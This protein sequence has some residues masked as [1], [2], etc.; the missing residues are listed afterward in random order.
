[1]SNPWES[2]PELWKT[3]ASFMSYVRGGIRRGLWEKNPVKLEFIKQNREKVP[4]GKKTLKNPDGMVWGCKC[5]L[6][7]DL[8]R[9][10]EC[11]VD[12]KEG[13]H[14]LRE[15]EQ[16]Q[17][18]IESIVFVT[19]EDL[20]MVCKGCHT[21]KSY[22]ERQDI[23]FEEARFEKEVIAFSKKKVNEQTEILLALDK[24]ADIRN[25][26]TRK[27]EYRRLKQQ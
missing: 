12:H 19:F 26:D 14:S 10:A 15:I 9:Q 6:C 13:N 21:I 24:E 17:Q 22:A 27:K 20:Q 11:Q 1:M 7:G 25:A 23:T 4:L 2:Y 8:F 5:S 18:F 3:K 16:I